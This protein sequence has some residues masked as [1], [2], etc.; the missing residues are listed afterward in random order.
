MNHQTKGRALDEPATEDLS[1]CASMKEMA[2][3]ELWEPG[4]YALTL[5]NHIRNDGVGFDQQRE[6]LR[7]LAQVGGGLVADQAAADELAR[8]FLILSALS[9][10]LAFHAARAA[11]GPSRYAAESTQRLTSA[12]I[13]AQQAS[14]ACLGALRQIRQG[15]QEGGGVSQ[16]LGTAPAT[17]EPAPAVLVDEQTSDNA[18]ASRPY[19]D[20]GGEDRT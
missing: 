6:R 16:N 3:R 18:S 4:L 5:A 9:D 12:A 14:A 13:K 8:H 17:P 1:G 10:K 15:A 7:A 19:A 2:E 20:Q 11:D